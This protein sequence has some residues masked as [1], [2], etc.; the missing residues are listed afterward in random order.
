MITKEGHFT[1]GQRLRTWRKSSR[2]KLMDL[3]EKINVAASSLSELEN[4]KSLPSADT[5]SKLYF[6]TDIDIIWLLT[7]VG[8]MLR[9]KSASNDQSIAYQ[10]DSSSGQDQRL[11]ELIK[12]VVRIYHY[13]EPEKVAHLNGFLEGAD[14]KGRLR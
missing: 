9:G 2:M 7:G 11:K 4:D 6:H 12:K 5:L 1:A 10:D 8:T 13:G 3:S 14:P